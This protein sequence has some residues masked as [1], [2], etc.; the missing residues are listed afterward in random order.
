MERVSNGLLVP[1]GDIKALTKAMKKLL[2]DHEL[3]MELR[4][5]GG[6]RVRQ[7]SK[8]DIAKDYLWHIKQCIENK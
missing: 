3:Q 8:H 4:S 6:A 7:F 1:V 2:N 5:S